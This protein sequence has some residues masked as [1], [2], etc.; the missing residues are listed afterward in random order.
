MSFGKWRQSCLGLNVLEKEFPDSSEQIKSAK[1]EQIKLLSTYRCYTFSIKCT[2]WN[3]YSNFAT[4]WDIWCLGLTT[5]LLY[6]D[7]FM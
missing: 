4:G 6:G 3:K 7:A 1:V 2:F 5:C